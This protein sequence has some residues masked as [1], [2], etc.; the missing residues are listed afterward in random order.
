MTHGL[1]AVA[2]VQEVEMRLTPLGDGGKH[3]SAVADRFV[4]GDVA[5]STIGG[6][7]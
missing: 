2:A 7:P 6:P 1:P 4:A 5:A 3:D